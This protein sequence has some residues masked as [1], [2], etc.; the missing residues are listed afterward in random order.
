MCKHTNHLCC[1][2][3]L[4]YSLIS[5][6]GEFCIP[7]FPYDSLTMDPVVYPIYKDEFLLVTG[8]EKGCGIGVFVS[9]AGEPIRGTL[10]WPSMPIKVV[11]HDS[12][13]ISLLKNS[14]IQIHDIET[15]ALIQS[16]SIPS[17]HAPKFM[18]LAAYS[19]DLVSDGK[20]E[21][22]LDGAVIHVVFGT[23]VAVYGLVMLSWDSQLYELF[24]SNRTDQ[25]LTLLRKMSENEESSEQVNRRASFY[26]RAGFIFLE[27]GNF[28]DALMFFKK[29]RIP[30]SYLIRLFQPQSCRSCA[31]DRP[32]TADFAGK[33]ANLKDLDAKKYSEAFDQAC[34]IFKNDSAQVIFF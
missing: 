19:M 18:T 32:E 17:S 33:V 27:R 25:A 4:V 5:S 30:P 16:I 15:Q 13:V 11:Y 21:S 28:S 1:A 34:S 20:S 29:C 2:D 22:L 24:Q 3:G 26:C 23:A 6:N 14:T 10:Q 8:T 31:E 12:F 9:S 7:L